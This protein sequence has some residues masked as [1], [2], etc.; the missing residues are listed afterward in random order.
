VSDN[1]DKKKEQYI[2][3]KLFETLPDDK[4][5]ALTESAE[6]RVIPACKKIFGQGDPGDE[7]YIVVSGKVRIS[8]RDRYGLDRQLA[9]LG[10]RES[11]GQI[12]LLTGQVRSVDVET[13]EETHLMIL[14]KEQFEVVL[15][16]YP[17][18]TLAVAKQLSALIV[19]AGKA[20]DR[21]RQQQHRAERLTWFHVVVVMAIGFLLAVVFNQSNPNGIP[22]FLKVP[23][24][25]TVPAIKAAQ[26]MEEMKKSDTLIVDAGPEGFYQRKHIRGA[27][28]VPLS[29][30][31]VLYEVTFEGEEKAKNVIVYGRTFSKLYD[32]ELAYRL[33]RKGRK[34]VRV[35]DG[36][37]LAWEQ[38]GYPVDTWEE[39]K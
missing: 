22:L 36:G 29:L 17:E 37:V 1:R 11:F 8:K 2:R 9:V 14:T 30:F 31:D 27:I 34:G 19:R 12:P 33:I 28:N 5:D 10:P 15:K 7:F 25:D 3:N 20:F 6:H 35:L 4:W 26:A 32:F 18:I 24:K 39:K 21:E 16:E 23:V 13:I 38:A